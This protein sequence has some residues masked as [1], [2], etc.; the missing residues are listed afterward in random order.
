MCV[1]PTQSLDGEPLSETVTN[2]SCLVPELR[3]NRAS[4]IFNTSE[5]LTSLA[6]TFRGYIVFYGREW[7]FS[8][9]SKISS[10]STPS[11]L[12]AINTIKINCSILYTPSTNLYPKNP[13]QTKHPKHETKN[14]IT[15]YNLNS[16]LTSF[17]P[18][19][20]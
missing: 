3:R 17:D 1:C 14:T 6:K 12:R 13:P 15:K 18:H 16:N 20:I 4:T 8:I 19:N 11:M 10:S 5:W 7:H 2:F 9:K